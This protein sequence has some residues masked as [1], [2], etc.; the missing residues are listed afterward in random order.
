MHPRSKP[1]KQRHTAHRIWCRIRGEMP[2]VEVAESTIRRYVHSAVLRLGARSDAR[3][4]TTMATVQPA[5][6]VAIV[7]VV[8]GDGVL[9][10][11]SVMAMLRQ[12]NLSRA[13][14]P[15]MKVWTTSPCG[16]S[17]LGQH[18]PP[19]VREHRRPRGPLPLRAM[20][21]RS[22]STHRTT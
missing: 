5:H 13:V 12:S 6:G 16:G 2:E 11:M 7:E 4:V 10:S 18:L 3:I 8:G 20:L 14:L 15:D 22:V 21:R 1:R 9:R 19:A 17:V